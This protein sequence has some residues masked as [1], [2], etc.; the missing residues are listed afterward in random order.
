MLSA[1]CRLAPIQEG[2]LFHHIQDAHSGVDIEQLVCSFDQ[3]V[4]ASS[5]QDACQKL[6]DRYDVLR[7]SFH[8]EGVAQPMQ[9]VSAGVGALFS[10]TDLTALSA[11]AQCAHLDGFLE[12]DRRAGFELDTPPLCRFRLFQLGVSDCK[13]VWTFHH[14]ILDGRSFPIVL[15]ELFALYDGK[16]AGVE[17]QLPTPRPYCDY[18]AWLDTLELSRAE[19]F[20]KEYLS[21]FVLANQVPAMNSA[22]ATET[23][24]GEQEIILSPAAT[25]ALRK[26]AAR[27]EITLNT[28]LQGAWALI[29]SRYT[30]SNDVVF[31]ATRACRNFSADAADRVGAFINT[32]P[33][34][35][36]V[37]GDQVLSKWLKGIRGS[38]MAVR[39]YEHTSL[40]SIQAWSEAPHGTPLF[41]SIL[42]F[43]NYDLNSKMQ[44]QGGNWSH[45]QVQLRER[46]NY[47][48]TL[49][50]ICRRHFKATPGLRW[51]AF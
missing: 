18:I 15:N 39:E 16:R 27:E 19:R 22:A 32:L 51:G 24:R 26:R 9:R 1:G 13:L 2:M 10:I 38:Q 41:E 14:A 37:D 36:P 4:D 49:Y 43:D 21:G 6:V 5:L 11:Q 7:T 12:E 45:R 34:R 31:G 42:V 29:L 35:V 46:T 40:A 28:I 3:A 8:W 33:V 48:L 23:G 44:S 50:G 30:A 20:W 25:E 47:P 17:L